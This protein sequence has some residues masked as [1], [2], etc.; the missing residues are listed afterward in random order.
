MLFF[1]PSVL[2]QREEGK[3]RDIINCVAITVFCGCHS[4]RQEHN[5]T[6]YSLFSSAFN[7]VIYYYIHLQ[8]YGF[9]D[10]IIGQQAG[11]VAR[12]TI[13]YILRSAIRCISKPYFS[14]A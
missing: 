6:I 11:R 7:G 4:S 12:R 5:A 8:C 13:N 9:S 10:R 2:V 3:V 14:F 1:F